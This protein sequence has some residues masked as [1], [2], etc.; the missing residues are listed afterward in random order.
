M[1]HFK[2]SNKIL[3]LGL[4]TSELHV[5]TYLCS[6]HSTTSTL[7]GDLVKVKQATIAEKCLINKVDTVSNIIS[8]LMQ[9]GLIQRIIRTRK[10]DGNK[11]TNSYILNKPSL[12]GGY[13]YVDR[14][15][16]NGL[17]NSR[18]MRM[19]LFMS[20]S[21]NNKLDY[22]WNS[23][24]DISKQ[25]GI[26]RS[27]AIATIKELIE[28]HVITKKRTKSRDNYKIF[29]DNH[30][31]IIFKVA[32]KRISRKIKARKKLHFLHK[33][34]HMLKRVHNC[35]EKYYSFQNYNITISNQCQQEFF[36]SG[37]R[38]RK[39]VSFILPNLSLQKKE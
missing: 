21:Y 36:D 13:F 39:R 30:Y 31:S 33:C 38:V 8:R 3:D 27:D 2:L 20:R 7:L 23:Y 34:S 1:S 17:L 9:K 14:F 25:L 15:N 26:K 28:L 22:C 18:Q 37:G 29:V 12:T 4:T 35:C 24:A 10:A 5:F 11:G 32:H 6:I 16:F 19:F